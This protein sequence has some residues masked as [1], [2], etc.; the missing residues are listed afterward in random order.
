MGK[1]DPGTT[2]SCR[3]TLVGFGLIA[4]GCLVSMYGFLAKNLGWPTYAPD[5]AIVMLGTLCLVFG[6]L[7]AKTKYYRL[8]VNNQAFDKAFRVQKIIGWALLLVFV[9]IPTAISL[10][11]GN[12]L[13]HMS[14]LQIAPWAVA[15]FGVFLFAGRAWSQRR[16]SLLDQYAKLISVVPK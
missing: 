11:K 2:M 7:R 4:S 9:A 16:E 1:P 10:P 8:P 3:P 12:V 14:P 13:S 5:H 15:Y 6:L